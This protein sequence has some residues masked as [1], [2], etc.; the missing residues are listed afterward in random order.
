MPDEVWGF[1]RQTWVLHVTAAHWM[2]IPRE[3][4]VQVT[5]AQRCQCRHRSS[6]ICCGDNRWNGWGRQFFRIFQETLGKNLWYEPWILRFCFQNSTGL[7]KRKSTAP[8]KHC[9]NKG[10]IHDKFANIPG[11]W[12]ICG[13]ITI[14]NMGLAQ[15]YRLSKLSKLVYLKFTTIDSQSCGSIHALHVWIWRWAPMRGFYKHPKAWLIN[16]QHT[17]RR[18]RVEWTAWANPSC[19][20]QNGNSKKVRRNPHFSS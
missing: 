1:L 20:P 3:F 16:S 14:P 4:L 9:L 12:T 17:Q 18:L 2:K 7:Y 5:V 13:I 15:N 10:R 11:K 8:I 6:V 19:E